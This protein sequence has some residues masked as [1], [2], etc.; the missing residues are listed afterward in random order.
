MRA[1]SCAMP[2]ARCGPAVATCVRLVVTSRPWITP[3]TA[4]LSPKLS[5][6]SLDADVEWFHV[7][8]ALKVQRSIL[9]A[10]TSLVAFMFFDP[11]SLSC[12]SAFVSYLQGAKA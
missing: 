9:K 1:A 12:F 4:S 11:P 5:D 2:V 3:P 6:E 7:V 8:R 10:T